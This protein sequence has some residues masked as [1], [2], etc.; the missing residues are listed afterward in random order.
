MDSTFIFFKGL[1]M[2]GTRTLMEEGTELS[3]DTLAQRAGAKPDQTG[4]PHRRAGLHSDIR[5]LPEKSGHCHLQP[6]PPTL[7][8]F[9]FLL[10]N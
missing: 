9:L 7:V 1:S 3:S 2:W 8:L 5:H 4:E 6:H 10:L